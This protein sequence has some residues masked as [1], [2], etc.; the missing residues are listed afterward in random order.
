MANYNPGTDTERFFLSSVP[1]LSAANVTPGSGGWGR[2][3]Y[4]Y[5]VNVTDIDSDTVT[6]KFWLSKEGGAWQYIVNK[7]GSNC[8]NS[9]LIFNYSYSSSDLGNWSFKFNATDLHSNSYELIG[10][11]HVVA[12]D[13]IAINHFSGNNS[14]VNRSDLQPGTQVQLAA[15]VY[16]SDAVANITAIGGSTFHVYI[17]N[18][19]STWVELDESINNTNATLGIYYYVDFNPTCNYTAAQQ[20]WNMSVYSDSTYQNA[21]SLNFV[22]NVYGISMR[23]TAA[24]L[25]WLRMSAAVQSQSRAICMTIAAAQS[26]ARQ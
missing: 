15:F 17:T 14:N 22:V 23:H 3:N 5:K 1:V 11:S 6:V 19:T 13:T 25:A 16:D 7:T 12:K 18:Q 8:Q 26:A 10:G 24:R 2:V 20:L 21:S 9:Q 4:T